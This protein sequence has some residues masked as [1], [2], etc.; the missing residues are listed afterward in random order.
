[1]VFN[2]LRIDFDDLANYFCP[3]LQEVDMDQ[4]SRQDLG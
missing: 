3:H 2:S 4:D 1:M